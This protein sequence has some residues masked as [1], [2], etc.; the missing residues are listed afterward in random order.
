M[1]FESS[2]L[3]NARSVVYI[4]SQNTKEYIMRSKE[5]FPI[6]RSVAKKTLRSLI[7]RIWTIVRT[8]FIIHTTLISIIVPSRH[9]QMLRFKR[10]A[11]VIVLHRHVH[12]LGW[13]HTLIT[14]ARHWRVHI[15]GRAGAIIVGRGSV[16]LTCIAVIA[17]SGDIL[18]SRWL[19]LILLISGQFVY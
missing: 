10:I 16:L 19:W 4:Q 5:N 14:L 15:I 6:G 2:S 7:L 8:V 12:I 17:D 3:K 11:D 18:Y 1:E 9:H 13:L